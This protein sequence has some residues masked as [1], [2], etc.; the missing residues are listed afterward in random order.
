MRSTVLIRLV[1]AAV[2]ATVSTSTAA[3]S[4][5]Q[6]AAGVR[7]ADIPAGAYSIVAEVRAKPGKEAE[8]RKAT[9][10][11][12][13]QVRSDPKNLVYFLQED[14]EAPGRFVFY[15][16]FATREDFEAHNNMPYVKEWLAKLPALADGGVTVTR[17]QILNGDAPRTR[18]SLVIRPRRLE[19]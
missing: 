15:E 3:P 4:M 16:V 6:G 13:A 10:P 14:R 17:M 9:L 8:L 12:V 11:L 18:S 7:Y 1:L 2:I 19:A 5:A